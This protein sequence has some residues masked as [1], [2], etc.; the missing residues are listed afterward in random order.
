MGTMNKTERKMYFAVKLTDRTYLGSQ[1]GQ[2]VDSIDKARAYNT[3]QGA[4][5]AAASYHSVPWYKDAKAIR[6]H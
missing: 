2:E 4:E 5:K 3:R 6:T 1:R